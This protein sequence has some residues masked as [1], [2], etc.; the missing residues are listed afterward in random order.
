MNNNISVF[1]K[2]YNISTWRKRQVLPR[3]EALVIGVGDHRRS[4]A[5]VRGERSWERKFNVRLEK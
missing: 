4:I 2:N 3:L 5:Q 1:C